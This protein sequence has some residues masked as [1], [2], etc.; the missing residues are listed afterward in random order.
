MQAG[1][2][3]ADLAAGA[4]PADGRPEA[5][6]GPAAAAGAQ[7]APGEAACKAP[8]G[9]GAEQPCASAAAA[10]AEAGGEGASGDAVEAADVAAEEDGDAEEAEEEAEEEVEEAP[11]TAEALQLAAAHRDRCGRRPPRRRLC[12]A[13][14][15][16]TEPVI[17][18]ALLE[19][20]GRLCRPAPA[21]L[22]PTLRL[23]RFQLEVNERAKAGGD[24]FDEMVA[25]EEAIRL[26][27][28]GW[29]CRYYRVRRAPTAPA[30]PRRRGG[31]PR[32]TRVCQSA[33]G[34]ASAGDRV[35]TRVLLVR[36][37][38]APLPRIVRWRRPGPCSTAG[39]CGG[40]ADRGPPRQAKLGVD[41]EEQDQQ[42]RDMVR[43]YVEGLCWIMRYYYD[44][45]PGLRAALSAWKLRLLA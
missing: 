41:G 30:G 6:A 4:V 11:D 18:Q 19:H 2:N 21:G 7:A 45:A 36:P 12:T 15:A 34:G 14:Q 39:R 5:A 8:A 1:A 37:A 40:S 9:A 10:G 27:E 35:V 44:G 43:A 20:G 38:Q 24:M 28:D 31:A 23:R 22:T 33:S 26:G 32:R 3:G 16:A 29:K 17:A 13:W 42:R 25:H